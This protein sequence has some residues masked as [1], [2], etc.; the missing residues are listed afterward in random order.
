ML[1]AGVTVKPLLSVAILIALSARAGPAPPRAAVLVELFTSQGCSSCPGAEAYLDRLRR[2]QPIAGAEVI[3]VALHVDYFD[4]AGWK[5]VFSSPAFSQRQEDYAR[6]LD[7]DVYTPQMVVNGREAVVATDAERVNR[8]VAS[9]A[10]RVTL[11]IHVVAEELG[12]R[13]HLRIRAPAVPA[14]GEQ[15]AMV[16]AITQD[17]LTTDVT[18]GENSG[19]RLQQVAVARRLE[20]LADLDG[21]PRTVDH[22]IRIDRGWGRTGLNAVVW[23]QGRTSRQVYGAAVQSLGR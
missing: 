15:I 12:G 6:V 10:A 18:R 11:S 23:L 16:A 2:E 9:A 3:P 14:G 7:T 20:R 8:A 22:A 19:R 1:D 13:V 21:R 17:G 5:D 4:R